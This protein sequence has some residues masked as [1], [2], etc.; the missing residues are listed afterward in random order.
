MTTHE[1]NLLIERYLNGETTPAE[2]RALALAV[3]REDRPAEWAII[4]E[5]LGE[6]TQDEALYD[7]IMAQRAPKSAKQVRP[8]AT[9]LVKLWPWAAAACAVLTVG[10]SYDIINKPP[11]ETAKTDLPLPVQPQPEIMPATNPPLAARAKPLI[12][13]PL[14]HVEQPLAK[15]PPLEAQAEEPLP[16]AQTEEPLPDQQT[17]LIAETEAFPPQEDLSLCMA[18]LAEVEAR[19]V[20]LQQAQQ[21]HPHTL[22]EGGRGEATTPI[23]DLLGDVVSTPLP[24]REG[25]GV[26]LLLLDE[27]LVNIQQQS[28]RPELSL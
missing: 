18:L 22:P 14:P 21:A 16:E 20:M 5:M 9:H 11:Q 26:G 3:Q 25:Q 1:I 10:L 4:A 15:A 7:C 17:Q 2:E 12:Q 6:L 23:N 28:N 13:Q 24:R 8:T 19:A 27:I